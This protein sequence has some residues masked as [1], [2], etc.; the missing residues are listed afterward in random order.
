MHESEEL[1][2]PAL[3]SLFQIGWDYIKF[4]QEL[5]IKVYLGYMAI[6]GAIIAF[7]VTHTTFK[8]A[9]WGL[10]VPIIMGVPIAGICFLAL[11]MGWHQNNERFMAMMLMHLGFTDAGGPTSESYVMSLWLVAISCSLISLV[12]IGLFYFYPN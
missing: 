11:K 6:T 8:L 2:K 10:W 4:Y 7:W 3:I 12:C 1:H 5:L 9:V